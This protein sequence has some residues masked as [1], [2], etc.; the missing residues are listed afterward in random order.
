MWGLTR[1]LIKRFNKN[2]ERY[3]AVVLKQAAHIFSLQKNQCVCAVLVVKIK[4]NLFHCCCSTQVRAIYNLYYTRSTDTTRDN[5]IPELA[6]C[7]IVNSSTSVFLRNKFNCI[8]QSFAKL[9]QQYFSELCEISFIVFFL[10]CRIRRM[11]TTSAAFF[12]M[13]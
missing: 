3:H 5:Q 9:V 8:F 7:E 10:V 2:I 13:S 4:I 6:F 1:A 12:Q 11:P